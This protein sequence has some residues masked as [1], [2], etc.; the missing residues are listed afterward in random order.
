MSNCMHNPPPPPNFKWFHVSESFKILK[1][2]KDEYIRIISTEIEVGT[3][4][5]DFSV[6]QPKRNTV[7]SS[8]KLHNLL[9]FH[10]TFSV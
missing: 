9:F 6:Q 1:D 5:L 7:T 3:E 8:S 2:Y 10:L 4:T